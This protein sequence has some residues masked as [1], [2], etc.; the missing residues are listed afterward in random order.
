MYGR[1][2]LKYKMLDKGGYQGE[3]KAYIKEEADK[4]MNAMKKDNKDLRHNLEDWKAENEALKQRVKE[5]EKQNNVLNAEYD[6]LK[7]ASEESSR[8]LRNNCMNLLNVRT[9]KNGYSRG[10]VR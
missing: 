1:E 4:V 5:L 2:K 9:D 8:N 7:S 6:L 10:N 3:T